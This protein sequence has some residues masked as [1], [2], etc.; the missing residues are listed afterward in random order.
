MEGDT[1]M[2]KGLLVS[3]FRNADLGDS[4]NGGVSSFFSKFILTGKG[5]PEIFS[6]NSDAPELRY[7]V[8][9]VMP[10]LTRIC[11]R[12]VVNGMVR[13][14]EEHD[15]RC[16]MF[17]GNFVYTCDSRFPQD[18]PI[19]VHDRGETAEESRICGD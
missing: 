17:G 18:F 15:N 13:G 12:P 5:L 8:E 9:E 6:P 19:P 10:G 11:A 14:V 2:A 7:C 1:N 16:W 4:T 3:V